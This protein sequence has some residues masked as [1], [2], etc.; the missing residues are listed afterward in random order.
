MQNRKLTLKAARGMTEMTQQEMAKMLGI[1]TTTYRNY[2]DGKREM[3]LSTAFKFSDIVGL[4]VYHIIF[5]DENVAK[6]AT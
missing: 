1:S 4:D 3:P 6:I 5:F 2:E